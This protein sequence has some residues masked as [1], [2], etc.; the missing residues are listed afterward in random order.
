MANFCRIIALSGLDAVLVV[1]RGVAT[2]DEFAQ[3]E[4]KSDGKQSCHKISER[5]EMTK[6]GFNYLIRL[7]S[8]VFSSETYLSLSDENLKPRKSTGHG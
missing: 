2:P 3:E 1:I 4:E 5:N 6:A 7:D 8:Y